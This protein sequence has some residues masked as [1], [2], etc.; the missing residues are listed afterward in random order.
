MTIK[1]W[2]K[3]YN[4]DESLIP[5]NTMLIEAKKLIEEMEVLETQLSGAQ[6]DTAKYCTHMSR[7]F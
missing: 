4:D 6:N 7:A 1:E 5:L 2:L 3:N